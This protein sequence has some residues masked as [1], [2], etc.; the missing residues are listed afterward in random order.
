M[1]LCPDTDAGHEA[2]H[3]AI[4]D[5]WEVV[6]Q[7]REPELHRRYV[8]IEHDVGHTVSWINHIALRLIIE[9]E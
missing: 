4:Q 6:C 1:I 3:E 9:K 7:W 2:L 5:G 8:D